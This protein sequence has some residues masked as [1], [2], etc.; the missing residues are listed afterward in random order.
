M[1]E[2]LI[3]GATLSNGSKKDILVSDGLITKVAESI[4]SKA[5]VIEAKGLIA[6]SGF[7]DLH[8]HL[9][10]PGFEQSETVLTGS[11]A[12]AKGGYTAVNAMANTMPVADSAAVVEQ[13]YRLGVEA[14][15]VEVKPI[16]AVSLALRGENLAELASMHRSLANVSVFSDDG[17]CVSDPLLMRRALEYVKSFDGVIAQHAQEP[18]LTVGAQMNEGATATKLGLAGWPSVA[19]SS[20]VA[21]DALLAEVTGSKLHV[22]H[23]STK[24]TVDVVR[25]AK[26]RGISITAEVTPHHLLLTEDMVN[27]YNTV[28]KVNPPLRTKEDVL[29]LR[30]ALA[31]GTIDIVATDHAPHPKQSKDCDWASAANGMVGLETAVSVVIETMVKTGLIDWARFEE[32]MSI[33]PALIA[34]M[35]NQGRGISE[36]AP[37]NITL[38]DPSVERLVNEDTESLSANNPYLGMKLTGSVQ[39]VLFAGKLTVLDNKVQE[40]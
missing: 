36:G 8:T 16:G 18:R 7:V 30:E 14:G 2:F 6:L 12:A 40:F 24:E 34:Q 9:R 19:E 11:R 21:R 3:K 27:D 1:N 15:Y 37:A 29:A 13:V 35:P 5:Q 4:E 33:Q 20:I 39:H 23:V 26:S 38:I 10:Q 17:N 22:C 31:D 28:Y 32:V 25:W